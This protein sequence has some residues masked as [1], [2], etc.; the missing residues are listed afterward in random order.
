MKQFENIFVISKNDRSSRIVERVCR[1]TIRPNSIHQVKSP[2]H[3]LEL[4]NKLGLRNGK[5]PAIIFLS[6]SKADAKAKDF[7]SLMERS[8]RKIAKNGIV[9]INENL[10]MNEMIKLAVSDCVFHFA[11]CPVVESEIKSIIDLRTQLE[12][13]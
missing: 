3:G 11:N 6:V 13:A 7:L 1:K 2:D 8:Y 10:P 12:T 9:V 4:I 5:I